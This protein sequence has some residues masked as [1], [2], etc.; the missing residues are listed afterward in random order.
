MKK[1]WL[2]DEDEFFIGYLPTAPEQTMRFLKR[3]VRGLAVVILTLSVVIVVSQRPFS[4]ARFEYGTWVALEGYLFHDPLPHLKLVRWDSTLETK[5]VQ[6]VPLVGFGK[7]G[8]HTAL[9]AFAS[10]SGPW[11]GKKVSLRGQL[12]QGYGKTWLQISADQPPVSV[13][14]TVEYKAHPLVPEETITVRGEMVDPKCFFGVMKPGEGKPH[15]SCAIRCIAGGIPPVFHVGDQFYLVLDEN[16]HPVNQ[17]ILPL[18]GDRLTLSGSVMT[19]DDW[20]ILLIE[21]ATLAGQTAAVRLAR[22]RAMMEQG[23]TQCGI[24]N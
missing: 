17:E 10:T 14:D 12:I 1:N 11:E 2:P 23:M 19:W 4:P 22:N 8:A 21:K 16:F 7:A 5:S 6:T 24:S 15:R 3:V 18:V 9:A 13:P 20:K